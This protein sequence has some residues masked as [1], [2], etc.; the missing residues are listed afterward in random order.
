MNIHVSNLSFDATDKD[1][2]ELFGQYGEVVSAKIITDRETGRS[3]GFG[4]VEMST[5]EA[6]QAAIE[7]LNKSEFSGRTL[8]VN[9]ARP[10]EERPAGGNRG[11][12]NRDNRGGF[13]RDNNRNRNFNREGGYSSRGRNN[14]RDY[15]NNEE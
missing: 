5:D 1:L 11:G 2:N 4:F 6:A 10:R 7:A 8:N 9:E 13:N 12:F 14:Y 15:N 3:R